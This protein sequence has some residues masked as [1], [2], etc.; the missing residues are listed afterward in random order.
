MTWNEELQVYQ[1]SCPCGDLF[2]ISLVR[3][4]GG[5]IHTQCRERL[6]QRLRL[7]MIFAPI[8]CQAA[9]GSG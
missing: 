1:Y 3:T 7:T 2:E 5:L 6:S 8:V 4:S 9:Q